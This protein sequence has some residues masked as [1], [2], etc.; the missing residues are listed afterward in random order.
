MAVAEAMPR[1]AGRS[2]LARYGVVALSMAGA[3]LL[4]AVVTPF[5]GTR[6]PFL[7]FFAAVTVSSWYGGFWP[8]VVCTLLGALATGSILRE[9]AWQFLLLTSGDVLALGI[10]VA[11]GL[12]I[13]AL[14]EALRRQTDEAW[15]AQRAAAAASRA[16]DE[17]LSAVSHELRTPL[18]SILGWAELMTSREMGA[19]ERARALDTILRN[20][21][22]QAQIVDDLLD[23]SRIVAGKLR[24]SRAP[25][26]LAEVVQ[27]AVD[28]IAPAAEAKRISLAVSLDPEVGTV[29]AD[30]DRIRQIAWNLLSNA[31]KFSPRGGRVEVRLAPVDDRIELRVADSGQGIARDFLPHVFERFTQEDA[32]TTRAHRGLG[33]GLAI[34]QSLVELHGGEIVAESEGPGQG[35]TFVVTLPRVLPGEVTEPPPAPE[36]K[37]RASLRGVRVLVVDDDPDTLSLVG[38]ILEGG[39]ATIVSA[40]SAREALR[41]FEEAPIDVLVS[42]IGMPEEDGYALLAK[43]RARGAIRALALTAFSG[44]ENGLR[45]TSAGFQIHMAKPVAPDALLDAVASLA[46]VEG[47]GGA[48]VARG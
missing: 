5:Y 45:A 6:I 23:V 42:D 24:L 18:T 10:F 3:L 7:T 37:A 8:G 1:R 34:T 36:D 15:R 27:G 9:P 47:Q 12:C 17:F 48:D 19:V 31:V 35:A 40:T 16:K 26:R 33:L 38:A 13:S 28:V 2:W 46:T 4:R 29:V 39:G 14:N 41:R 25:T 43:L 11:T 44:P 32:G 21:R 20:A 22:A 30:P